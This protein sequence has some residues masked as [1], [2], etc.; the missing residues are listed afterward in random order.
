MCRHVDAEKRHQAKMRRAEGERM[1]Q[2]QH[3]DRQRREL[4][5][6]SAAHHRAVGVL[7]DHAAVHRAMHHGDQ[8]LSSWQ[9]HCCRRNPL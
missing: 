8:E 3:R 2:L 1:Q 7:E 6:D 4:V 9:L 5:H